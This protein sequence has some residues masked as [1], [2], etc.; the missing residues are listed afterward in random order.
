MCDCGVPNNKIVL[1]SRARTDTVVTEA[2]VNDCYRGVTLTIVVD[3]IT[4]AAPGDGITPVVGSVED[5]AAFTG[6]P[7]LLND[8]QLITA[9]GTYIIQLYPGVVAPPI[10][11][12]GDILEQLNNVLPAVWA[13]GVIHA[14]NT[15]ATYSV[16]A[17]MQ[18]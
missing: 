1:A 3:S 10:G 14:N 11:P 2:L 13:V 4:I 9:T 7:A 17:S 12:R 8:G 5:Q 18:P 15:A 6:G 16:F